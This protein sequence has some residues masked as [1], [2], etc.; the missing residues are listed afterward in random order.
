MKGQKMIYFIQVL[1][2]RN[3]NIGEFSYLT[4][5][6]VYFFTHVIVYALVCCVGGVTTHRSWIQTWFL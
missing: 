4:I 1:V 2:Q 6:I 3:N 5:W